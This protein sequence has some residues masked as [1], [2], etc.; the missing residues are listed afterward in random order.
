MYVQYRRDFT[1]GLA[2]SNEVRHGLEAGG[3]T[4]PA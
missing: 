4:L 3:S 2:R 1:R